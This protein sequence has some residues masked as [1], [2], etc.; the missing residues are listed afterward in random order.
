M[1]NR[2]L[3]LISV[4]YVSAG[5]YSQSNICNCYI[6]NADSNN[7]AV[8][9]TQGT[10]IGYP[11]AYHCDNC[12]SQPIKLPFNFCFYGKDYDTVYV[13]NKGNLSFEKPIFTF[14][15]KGFPLGADTLMLA[16]FYA[17]VDDTPQNPASVSYAFISYKLT[18]THLIVQW[19][20]IGYNTFDDDLY[21]YFQVTLTNGSD[22]I[23]PAGN[24][25]SYCYWL[26]QWASGDSSGGSAGFGGLPAT[27]GVN[28]GDHVHYA[29]F[30]AFDFPGH[31]YY[32]PFDTNNQV[33][34]LDNRSFIFNTCVSGNNIPPV[35]VKP[36]NLCDTITVCA[37]DT[38]SFGISFLCPQPGQTATFSTSS[39]GL[40]GLTS[41]N[42]SAHSIY[43]VTP[44]L[45]A[46]LKDTGTH[47]ITIKAIDNGA[48][49]LTDSIQFTVI[50]K[51]C[52]DTIPDL[53]INQISRTDNFTVFPNPNNG[54]FTIQML[55][56]QVS[57]TNSEIR[58][59]N[60]LG[61]NIYTNSFK[62]YN[63]QFKID[64]STQP[65]GVYF[66][67]IINE[68]GN[69]SGKGKFVIQ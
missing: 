30:G 55:N 52:G 2:L 69:S 62:T 56:G 35:I 64:L 51:P 42:N 25:V 22:S 1:R 39:P 15:S 47:I 43:T 29:Q 19:S 32:G 16:P 66:Y 46:H 33:Y 18:A 14:S 68:S 27:I 53:G 60:V 48:P 28:K 44:K 13:N 10:D 3:L 31:N 54:V 37:T 4:L 59:Y 12:S 6:I 11:P 7:P 26:M 5:A 41:S 49:P 45:I 20:G 8:P 67:R 40:S 38:V 9:L 21:D 63:S 36:P 61:E 65:S 24:N 50:I 58:I 17:D 23:L 57:I 34:W